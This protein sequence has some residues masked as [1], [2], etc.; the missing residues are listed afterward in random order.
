MRFWTGQRHLQ[1]PRLRSQRR[2]KYE[3]QSDL[4]Y[5]AMLFYYSSDI[6]SQLHVRLFCERET[7]RNTQLDGK[8]PEHVFCYYRLGKNKRAI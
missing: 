4:F 7:F 6:I 3:Q 1:R 5:N 8:E 2:C